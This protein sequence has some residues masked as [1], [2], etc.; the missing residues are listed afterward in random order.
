ML[1]SIFPPWTW[2]VAI[3]FVLVLV[4]L[5]YSQYTIDRYSPMQLDDTEEKRMR[6]YL[7]GLDHSVRIALPHPDVD[8]A[9]LVS[10]DPAHP[11]FAQTHP[12]LL[13]QENSETIHDLMQL[14]KR[15]VI[16]TAA[17]VK[18]EPW[19]DSIRWFPVPTIAKARHIHARTVRDQYCVLM[20]LRSQS[21]YGPV[22][23]DTVPFE[24]KRSTLVWRGGPSGPGFHNH[25]EARFMKPS[26]EDALKLWA[27]RADTAD[28]LDIGLI[29]KWKYHDFKQYLKPEL[30][31][32][33]MLQYKYILSIEGNDV[34]TNLKWALASQ[35]VV[36][37]PRPRVE[38]WLAES[39]L[40]PYTHYVPVQ[41]DFSDLLQQKR[42]ADK[43]PA[44]CKAIVARANAY[45]QPFLNLE[46][47]TYLSFKVLQR[48]MQHVQFG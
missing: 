1:E 42:W 17:L 47:E 7:G 46:R 12:A 4:Y 13:Q 35:S 43:H 8:P 6:V 9:H 22:R 41:D 48:Y 26:R 18:I 45:I 24:Q 29:T 2:W 11:M 5:S 28:D 27:N 33:E 38:S 34:A 30:K 21:H 31:I 25:Y 44:K 32:S 10:F 19:A 15:F 20:R 16:D 37:M 14:H 23:K 39:L 40:Q 36:F 3:A